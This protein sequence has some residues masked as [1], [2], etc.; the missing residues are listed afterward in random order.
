MY[1]LENFENKIIDITKFLSLIKPG[2]KIF[3]TS[4]PAIPALAAKEITTSENLRNYDLE[5]IQLFSTGNIFT[6]ESCD[7]QNYRL[8]IFRS[9]ET[10]VED[11]CNSRED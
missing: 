1:K 7:I 10:A 3:L 8:K 5:I 6:E 2:N 11:V 4:G 9:G